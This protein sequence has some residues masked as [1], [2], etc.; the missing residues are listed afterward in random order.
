MD[1]KNLLGRKTKNTVD[2]A[3]KRGLI[4]L[5]LQQTV[6]NGEGTLTHHDQMLE[7]TAANVGRGVCRRLLKAYATALSES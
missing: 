4:E 1:A 3:H 6:L 5:L 7:D 2:V